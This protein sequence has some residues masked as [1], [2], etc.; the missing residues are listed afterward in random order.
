MAG[1]HVLLCCFILIAFVL[2][3]FLVAEYAFVVPVRVTVDDASLRSLE[4]PA[5]P[6]PANG[7]GTAPVG[8]NVSVAVALSNRNWAMSVLLT[9]PLVAELRFRGGHALARAQL[10]CGDDD[11]ARIHA[12]TTAVYSM[13]GAAEFA[14]ER[15]AGVFELEVA[16]FAEV[17]YE[18]HPRR[19]AIRVTCLLRLSPSTAGPFERVRCA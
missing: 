19:R 18:A 2:A 6:A 10:A 12:L 11:R 17:K 15:A 3:A 14:R 13:A 4:A 8:Y 7:T 9:A 1:E 5:Q 16:V